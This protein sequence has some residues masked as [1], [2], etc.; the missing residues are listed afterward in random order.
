MG[1]HLHGYECAEASAV[2]DG[3]AATELEAGVSGIR[4]FMSVQ[5]SLAMCPIWKYRPEEQKRQWLPGPAAGE[6]VGCFGLTEPDPES[7]A[8]GMRMMARQDPSGHWVFNGAKERITNDAITDVAIVCARTDDTIRR[9]IIPT[10]TRG[11]TANKVRH[12]M[13]LRTSNTAELVLANVHPPADPVLTG[14]ANIRGYRSCLPEA[15]YGIL[16]GGCERRTRLLRDRAR[17]RQGTRGI[18]RSDRPVPA[19]TTAPRGDSGQGQQR[20]PVDTAPGSEEGQVAS[21]Q[22]SFGKMANVP[23]AMWIAR[24]ARTLM[25]GNGI[26]SEY[27]PIRHKINLESIC[28]S[29]GTNEIQPM[30]LGTSHHRARR[31]QLSR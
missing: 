17:L 16:W 6:L 30:I 7:S 21:T 28:S 18:R 13:S 22:V 5:G 27:P 11:F 29:E 20:H 14:V 9:F 1:I 31:L 24:E 4:S 3:L 12:K 2:E 10:D 23:K 15:R 8:A 26:T 19:D 25:G